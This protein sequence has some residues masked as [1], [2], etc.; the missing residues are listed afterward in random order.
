MVSKNFEKIYVTFLGLGTNVVKV[1]SVN[2]ELL[3]QWDTLV[4]PHG[5]L[6]L[7]LLN[8]AQRRGRGFQCPP[9]L[10]ITPD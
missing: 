7:K 10:D 1:I 5:N 6:I 8:V 9:K 4:Q 3:F 2:S